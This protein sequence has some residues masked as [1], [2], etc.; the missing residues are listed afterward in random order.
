MNA[1]VL[2][3]ETITSADDH[4]DGWN[5]KANFGVS[6]AGLFDLKDRRLKLYWGDSPEEMGELGERLHR[7]DY[8]VGF[9]HVDFDLPV[10]E[11][12]FKSKMV[13]VPQVH[14]NIDMMQLIF[15]AIRST[16]KRLRGGDWIQIKGNK[17]DA[18]L[19]ANGLMT[20]SGNGAEA[21]KLYKTGR[22]GK[23]MSYQSDDI[24]CEFS[25]L[26]YLATSTWIE[27]ACGRRVDIA[28]PEPFL[29]EFRTWLQGQKAAA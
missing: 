1:V 27:L 9:N 23:L 29:S 2:D 20:K 6:C 15:D 16:N 8:V 24:R 4:A 11:G 10:L 17:L 21:P 3:C 28:L 7:A 25:L 12:H 14:C 18:L 13:P 22:F 5:A 26:R 19:K